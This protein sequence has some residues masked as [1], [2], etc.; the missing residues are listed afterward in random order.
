MARDKT[1]E[2]LQKELKSIL[3]KITGGYKGRVEIGR[4]EYDTVEECAERIRKGGKLRK[5]QTK[6][7]QIDLD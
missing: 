1:T 7:Y 4:T 6:I 5:P 2:K 3:R